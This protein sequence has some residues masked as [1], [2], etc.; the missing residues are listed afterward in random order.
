M[1][2]IIFLI[3][4]VMFGTS[5]VFA[6]PTDKQIPASDTLNLVLDAAPFLGKTREE[7]TGSIEKF[8]N[9]VKKIKGLKSVSIVSVTDNNLHGSLTIKKKDYK[10]LL[11]K[12]GI[13]QLKKEL[14]G[15]SFVNQIWVWYDEIF[16]KFK[17]KS[18]YD[19]IKVFVLRHPDLA[20]G[21]PLTYGEIKDIVV[22]LDGIPKGKADEC[23]GL[24][25]TKFP[26]KIK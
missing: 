24:I 16:I 17:K 26:D 13:E 20:S 23:K 10:K 5:F 2:R 6:A 4:L 7:T 14:E 12:H 18:Y 1:K 22:S 25:K 9:E 3:I 21:V 15:D 11:D 19:D 8:I